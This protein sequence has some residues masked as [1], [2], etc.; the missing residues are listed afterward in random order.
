MLDRVQQEDDKGN[1]NS[2][3]ITQVPQEATW[4]GQGR[5]Q[6]QDLGPKLLLGP[7]DGVLWGTWAETKLVTSNQNERRFG[8]GKALGRREGSCLQGYWRS[9]SGTYFCDSKGCSLGGG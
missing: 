3:V 2:E 6:S 1:R 7:M 9:Q 4:G 5:A 8:E